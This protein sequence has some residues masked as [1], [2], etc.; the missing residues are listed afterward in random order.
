MREPGAAAALG[1]GLGFVLTGFLLPRAPIPASLIVACM[2][3]LSAGGLVYGVVLSAL[4]EHDD[5][6]PSQDVEEPVIHDAPPP[7]PESSTEGLGAGDLYPV[8]EES[9]AT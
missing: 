7:V 2:V 3:L 4:D 5:E 1:A 8:S 9:R 6:S